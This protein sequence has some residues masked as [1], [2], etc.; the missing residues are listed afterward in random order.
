MKNSQRGFGLVSVL[1]ALVAVI[2]IGTGIYIGTKNT[3]QFASV[4]TNKQVASVI[5]SVTPATLAIDPSTPSTIQ[6][7]SQTLT[8]STFTPPAGSELYIYVGLNSNTS[9]DS[10]N[11]LSQ[12]NSITNITDNLS[13]HLTYTQQAEQGAANGNDALTYLYTAPVTTSQPMTVSVTQESADQPVSYAMLKVI[14][15]TGANTSNPVGV[16]GGGRGATGTVS[17]TYTTTTAGSLG[18]LFYSDWNA[19]AIPT[20]GSG[21][22]VYKSYL[23]SGQDTYAIVQ[24]N[25]PSSAGASVT[26]NTVAPT[27]GAQT[28]YIYFE[29]LPG[30][31]TTTNNVYTI[32][33]TAGNG[34]SIS[35]SAPVVVPSGTGSTFTITP[36][37]GYQVASVSIDGANTTIPTTGGAYTFTNVG[38]DH[39]ISATFSST[40]VPPTISSISVSSISQSSTTINWTTSTNASDQVFYGLTTAYGS[41]SALNSTL[42]TSHSVVLSSLQPSTTYHYYIQSVDASGNVVKSPDQTFTT[43]AAIV[44]PT[45]Y[46]ITTSVSSGGSISP[47]GSVSALSGSSAPFTIT[48][49]SGYQVANVLV[50]GTSV[51]AVSTY[52]FSNVV[53]NHTIS[54]T[55]TTTTTPVTNPVAA[56]A[57]VTGVN[58]LVGLTPTLTGQSDGPTSNYELGTSFQSSAAGQISGIRFWKDAKETGTHVGHIWSSTGTLLASV[59]FTNETAS[60][61]QQQSLSSPLTI[62][63]NTSYVVSV[64]TGSTYYVATN[65]G[66][67]NT[68]TSGTLSSAGGG[69]FGT[70]GSFPTTVYKSTNYFRD[71]VFTAT[72]GVVTPPVT[73]TVAPSVPINL[74][75]TS[76][77]SSYVNLTWTASTD[78]VAVTGYNI[79]RGGTKIGTATTNSFTNTGLSAS[80]A[81]TYTVSAYDAAGNV[82]T[83]STSA[84]VTTLAASVTPP[85]SLPGITIDPS[86]PAAVKG[87]TQ[88]LTTA[89]FTPPV[90]SVIYILIGANSN[91]GG[92]NAISSVSD[93]LSTHLTYTKELEYG[94]ENAADSLAYLYTAPVTTS[95]PMKITVT[96]SNSGVN[97]ILVKTLV[98]TGVNPSAPIAAHGGGRGVTG[99]VSDSYTSTSAGSLGWLIYSDWVGTTLP[100]VS[101]NEAV[102]ISYSVSGD[103]S[104]SFIQQKS[105]S[106][107]VG[108]VVTLNTTAPTSGAQ[109]SHLYFEMNPAGGG[110]GG[111]VVPPT[112]SY[113]VTP[114]AGANGSISPSSAA[115]VTSGNSQTFTIT[116]AS[117]YQVANVLVDGT[118]VG[119]VSTYTFSNVVANHT[120]SAT[121]SATVVTPPATT[122]PPSTTFSVGQK[123][124]TFNTGTGGLSV[125]NAPSATAATVSGSP[126]ADGSVGTITAAPSGTVNGTYSGGIFWWYITYANGTVGWSA[127]T[128]LELNTT[129]PPPTTGTIQFDP[130]TPATVKASTQTISTASFTPPAGSVLYIMITGNSN[131]GSGANAISSIT[132]NLGTHLTYTKQGEYGTEGG[133]DSLTYLYTAPVTTSQSMTVTATQSNSGT[134]LIMMKVLVATGVNKASPVATIGGGSG[135]TG[136][137][138]DT[139]TAKSANS[140]GWLIYS[141]WVGTTL[142]TVGSSE[143][144][145]DSYSVAGDDSYSLIRQNTPTASIGSS[146][147]MNTTAPT[148]GV[149]VAHLYFEMNPSTGYTPPPDTTAPSIPTGLTATA[150][151]SSLINLTWAASTDNVGVA[152]YNIYRAGTKIGTAT[153]NSY[154]DSGLSASTAYSYTVSAYD[155][156]GNVSSQSASASATTLAQGTS[157][158]TSGVTGQL[159]GNILSDNRMIDWSKA[160]VVGPDGTPGIPTFPNCT[161]ATVTAGNGASIQSAIN[162]CPDHTVIN[163]PA[164]SYSLPSGLSVT[165]PV[166]L[167]GAGVSTV[168]T[169]GNQIKV[170]PYGG[171]W[172]GALTVDNLTGGYTKG[173]QTVTV[174]STAGLSVGK[175]V[176][177]DQ[178]NDPTIDVTA[179]GNEGAANQGDDARN[180]T[181]IFAG[182]TRV[183]FQME[184]ITAINGNTI[185]LDNPLYFTFNSN[186]QNLQPQI[187]TWS[188]EMDY[189]GIQNMKIDGQNS[190]SLMY[191]GFCTDCWVK[192][193]EGANEGKNFVVT[194]LGYRDSIVNNYFHGWVV[195][196]DSYD[197]DPDG[198]ADLVQ[199]NIVYRANEIIVNYP[200]GGSV[201]AYNYVVPYNTATG[202]LDMGFEPHAGHTYSNLYEGNIMNEYLE[203]NIWGSG[204]QNLVFRNRIWGY[205]P[206]NTGVSN[207]RRAV[208]FEAQQW[209]DSVIGNYLGTSGVAKTYQLDNNNVG[210][211]LAIYALGYWNSQQV[212]SWTSQFDSTVLTTLARWGNYDTVHAA[213]QWNMSEVPSDIKNSIGTPSQNIPASAYLPSQPSWWPSTLAYPAFGPSPTNPSTLLNGQIPAQYCYQTVMQN[214]TQPFNPAACYG[215]GQ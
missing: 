70:S 197:I 172:P 198:S 144:I 47:S 149:Q 214:G 158:N 59:T 45:T 71:V 84:T 90:G 126:V 50:D 66:F 58:L 152:G 142:P 130:S 19:Q 94:T 135:K 207:Y 64:N 210:S 119:A 177:L 170:S 51:G 205:D 82:S 146:V 85:P 132:D 53:A 20:A 105:P 3:S 192:D 164:G 194:T 2:I 23:V 89:S 91:S 111:Y 168:L 7:N 25:S 22:S 181:S 209:D 122:T 153:T 96:Q 116:P 68:I 196:T 49:A 215:Q 61:W 193:V 103:D 38:A 203:D 65:N 33:P 195:G 28:S 43:G 129:T 31:I 42:G 88:T 10:A 127:E 184:K 189:A 4:N 213:T 201:F 179:T 125:R 40:V 74:S 117:G 24:Q 102:N 166:V 109:I 106:A 212:T 86:T 39:T 97:L 107:N 73:D 32:T 124:Q 79:Y 147:T 12:K 199:N 178:L 77:S 208:D 80:T 148:T 6:S 211:D 67:A 185:T 204:S 75:A 26:M 136:V 100:T 56:P 206:L 188:N 145:Y 176:V 18:W 131:T 171:G 41:N 108:T 48:P 17:G 174:D 162:A 134:N 11:S 72:G 8:T 167:S 173:S 69:F 115:T 143:S 34:G 169:L 120:I 101:S 36:A 54:A 183:Q 99:T 159:L 180:G 21:Q 63:A 62:S 141:D 98:V 95:Q 163:I 9:T 137:I 133:N 191:F 37:S 87:S 123:I 30:S 182:N 138:S 1:I 118:S 15:V 60:G 83:Q 93:N 52:T 81:Y 175:T 113:I 202:N 140:I 161:S 155:A 5:T 165:H 154:S 112:T 128:Y 46:I 200:L 44:I 151:T 78:N 76:A 92:P 29:M 27:S 160:G 57:P 187:W 150:V 186:N 114:S 157:V 14:V 156:A 139:Y 16:K 110:G 121:F 13:S 104:Y 190:V 55:F 35:P